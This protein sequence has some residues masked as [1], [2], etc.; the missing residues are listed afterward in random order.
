MINSNKIAV[1]LEGGGAKGAYQIGVL[2]AIEE[3]GISYGCVV[4]TSI[5]AINSVAYVLGGY[6]KYIKHWSNM[7]FSYGNSSNTSKNKSIDFKKILNNIDKF[8][9]VYL[10]SCGIDAEPIVEMLKENIDEEAVRNSGINLGLTVYC[11][12]DKKP[13]SLFIDEIPKGQLYE[14]IFA[15]CNLPVFTP[16]P[17]NGKYYLDGSLVSKLPIHMVK[18]KGYDTA[19]AV[20]LR[21]DKYDYSGYENMNIIDIAPDEFLSNTL[22]AEKDRIKWMINEGY[23]DGLKILKENMYLLK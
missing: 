4:G 1:V 21:P 18:D 22:E 13:L 23:E 2:R 9:K 11:L 7:D 20:R 8:E 19:I 5:G 17:L 3:L 10:K 12:T 15:S 6:E 14:Y 16:R